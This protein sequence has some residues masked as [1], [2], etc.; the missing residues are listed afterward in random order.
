[1]FIYVALITLAVLIIVPVAWVFLGI[2]QAERQSLRQ[3]WTACRFYW[4]NFVDAWTKYAW[5]GTMLNSVVVTALALASCLSL[6]CP[7]HMCSP[8]LIFAAGLFQHGVHGRPVHQCQLYRRADLPDVVDGDKMLRKVFGTGFF[9]NNIFVLA[10]V[11]A[12]TALPFTIYLLSGYFATLPKA[13]EGARLLQD[14]RRVTG[15]A[16]SCPCSAQHRTVILFN[17]LVLERV[18]RAMTCS[19]TPTANAARGPENLM[20]TECGGGTADSGLECM[21]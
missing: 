2:R 4:Q 8:A 5:A 13:Y 18:H 11:Y 15:C 16:L 6:R 19:R 20:R 3:P 21:R 9:L 12:A 10:L 1:M 17:F 14:Q 7:P